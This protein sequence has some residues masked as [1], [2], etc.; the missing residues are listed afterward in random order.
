MERSAKRFSSLYISIHFRFTCHLFCLFVRALF[1]LNIYLC[2]AAQC[3]STQKNT[4]DQTNGWILR[5]LKT[6][7]IPGKP[8]NTRAM[9]YLKWDEH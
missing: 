4:P 2:S 7:S 1:G 5:L 9:R 8:K 3:V 6:I